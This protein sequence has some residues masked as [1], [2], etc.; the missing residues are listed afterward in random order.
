[1]LIKGFL[2]GAANTGLLYV[3]M[4]MWEKHIPADQYIAFF[5]TTWLVSALVLWICSFEKE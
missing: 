4:E 1:M 3:H 5:S 2:I